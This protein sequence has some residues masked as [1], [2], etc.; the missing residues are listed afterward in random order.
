MGRRRGGGLG[1]PLGWGKRSILHLR[2]HLHAAVEKQPLFGS[3]I[4]VV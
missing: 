3:I 4:S 2:A 1:A